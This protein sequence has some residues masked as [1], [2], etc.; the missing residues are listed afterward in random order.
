MNLLGIEKHKF[1]IGRE[2]YITYDD[3]QLILTVIEKPWLAE[4]LA[5]SNDKEGE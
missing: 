4:K 1:I 2:K 5:R 3:M